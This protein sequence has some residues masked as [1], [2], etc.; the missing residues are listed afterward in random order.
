MVSAKLR[1]ITIAYQF[2]LCILHH[3]KFVLV[4]LHLTYSKQAVTG[5]RE[6][7]NNKKKHLPCSSFLVTSCAL[8]DDSHHEYLGKSRNTQA[9]QRKIKMVLYAGCISV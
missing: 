2:K 9:L 6:T 3:L 4:T 1:Q 8:E 7:K 5:E